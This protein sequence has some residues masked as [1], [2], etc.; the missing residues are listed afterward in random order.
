MIPEENSYDSSRS[1]LRI[2]MNETYNNFI[3]FVKLRGSKEQYFKEKYI[4]FRVRFKKVN[5]PSKL[6][7]PSRP[8]W[9]PESFFVRLIEPTERKCPNI[10]LYNNCLLLKVESSILVQ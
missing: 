5:W 8:T 3:F 9:G 6:I 1:I 2:E 7:G 10:L 4:Q